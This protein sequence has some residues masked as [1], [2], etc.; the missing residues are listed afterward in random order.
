MKEYLAG[1]KLEAIDGT[2]FTLTSREACILNYALEG[3]F[4]DK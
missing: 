1:D 4:R 3:A 2:K